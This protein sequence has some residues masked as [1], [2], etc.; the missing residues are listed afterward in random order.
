MQRSKCKSLSKGSTMALVYASLASEGRF[1][2]DRRARV[3][4]LYCATTNYN[5]SISR[6]N[7]IS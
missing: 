3:L 4:V 7:L 1:R 5:T 6:K 2:K